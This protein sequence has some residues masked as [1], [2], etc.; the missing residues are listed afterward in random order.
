[1]ARFRIYA[2]TICEKVNG[3]HGQGLMFEGIFKGYPSA[4]FFECCDSFESCALNCI[5]FQLFN[6]LAVDIKGT[7]SRKKCEIIALNN[8]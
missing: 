4:K 7:F 2:V 8:S 6:T 1:M 5:L 3:R